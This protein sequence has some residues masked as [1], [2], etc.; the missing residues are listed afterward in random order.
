MT[1]HLI[2]D[3]GNRL[4]PPTGD[5]AFVST[6]A[7][8]F[9]ACAKATA[10]HFVGKG[11]TFEIWNEANLEHFWMSAPSASDYAALANTTIAA[12]H[13]GD[14]SAKVSTTGVSGYDFAFVRGYLAGGGA[15][16]I[17]VHPYRLRV[18]TGV[19]HEFRDY[20]G[21]GPSIHA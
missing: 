20:L 19:R 10:A 18:S 3:Y 7:P 8:A 1:L 11:V 9:A 13:A 14:P 2:L 6:T 15:D 16:A 12:V 4:Y 5:A 21:V 17:G